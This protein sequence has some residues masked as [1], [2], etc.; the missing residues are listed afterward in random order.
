MKEINKGKIELDGSPHQI[1]SK[2]DVIQGLNLDIPEITK[3]FHE[4][5][6]EFPNI[7]GNVYTLKYAINEISRC[8][9]Q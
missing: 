9:D 5:H 7:D 4:L 1:F 8:L 2:V 3:L 6:K